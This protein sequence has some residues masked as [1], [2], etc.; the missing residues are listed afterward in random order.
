[1]SQ[2][3]SAQLLMGFPGQEFH[4]E[5][6]VVM[7]DGGVILDIYTDRK[8]YEDMPP[9]LQTLTWKQ[10]HNPL[11]IHVTKSGR[12]RAWQFLRNHAILDEEL[13][14]LNK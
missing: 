9:E 1:M 3:T 5:F 7:S 10:G 14:E 4:G 6:N 8:H 12:D 2:E 11:F 13:E